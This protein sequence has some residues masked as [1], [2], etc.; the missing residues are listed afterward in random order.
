MNIEL[1]EV[2]TIGSGIIRLEG[3]MAV[4]VAAFTRRTG[5]VG[6]QRSVVRV[7]LQ[8]LVTSVAHPNNEY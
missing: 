6:V 1:S 5:V 3:V 2:K 4:D 7:K 8:S